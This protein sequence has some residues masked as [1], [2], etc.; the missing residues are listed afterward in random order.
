MIEMAS[1]QA[2]NITEYVK[3]TA[4]INRKHCN[5]LTEIPYGVF[6]HPRAAIRTFPETLHNITQMKAL[7]FLTL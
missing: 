6:I 1:L 3:I 2:Q 5:K 4:V 7:F